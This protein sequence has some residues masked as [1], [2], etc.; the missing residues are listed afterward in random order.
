MTCCP[1]SRPVSRSACG[2]IRM[3]EIATAADLFSCPGRHGVCEASTTLRH[4]H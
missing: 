3:E 1:R 4:K 2:P